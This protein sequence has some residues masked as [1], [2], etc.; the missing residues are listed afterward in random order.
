LKTPSLEQFVRM[1]CAGNS[2][3]AHIPQS[4]EEL[5]LKLSDLVW[6]IEVAS[7]SD[8]HDYC[9]R[10]LHLCAD[11]RFPTFRYIQVLRIWKSSPLGTMSFE[12]LSNKLENYN[13]LLE[14]YVRVVSP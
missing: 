9:S 5:I 10:L 7:L 14:T 6:L 11:G 8:Q 3:A 4:I 12:R 1:R 2:F 13:A